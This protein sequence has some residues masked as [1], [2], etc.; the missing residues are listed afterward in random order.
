YQYRDSL[1]SADNIVE[2]LAN[3]LETLPQEIVDRQTFEDVIELDITQLE[4][5]LNSI[6]LHP[7]SIQEEDI[8]S[9]SNFKNYIKEIA[10]DY[11]Q[12]LNEYG[13]ETEVLET[14]K[15]VAMVVIDNLWKS[16]LDTMGQVK[17][18]IGLRQYQQEDPI[19]I[20]DRKEV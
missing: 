12:G 8:E 2:Y 13:H 1:L 3:Q 20:L 11:Y 14:S 16:H 10:K 15:G 9:L 6:L 5:E 7:I 18:G 17:E 4:T 19:K